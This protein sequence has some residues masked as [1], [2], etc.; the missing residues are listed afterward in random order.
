MTVA[1]PCAVGAN[2][3]TLLNDPKTSGPKFH[4]KLLLVDLSHMHLC[5]SFSIS[6]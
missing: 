1:P 4:G 5:Q 3:Q 2:W 6:I